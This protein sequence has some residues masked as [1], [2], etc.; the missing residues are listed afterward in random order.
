MKKQWEKPV[1]C[2]EEFVANEY[3]AACIEGWIE[4]GYPGNGKT[5]GN[6]TIFDDY[7]GQETGWWYEDTNRKLP[8]GACGEK[9]KVIFSDTDASSTETTGR[10]IYNITGYEAKPG[11]YNN[12]SWNSYYGAE[13]HH[14][15]RIVVT[16]V[17]DKHPNHS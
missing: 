16:L 3:V 12:C 5:N 11:E 17:D 2:C 15:G 8:H 14:K 7:N 1:M 10:A 13:Y 9:T 4:C 6:P